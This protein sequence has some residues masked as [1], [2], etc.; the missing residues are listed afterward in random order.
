MFHYYIGLDLGQ[1]KDY[2]ALS[3]LEEPLWIGNEIAW[4]SYGVFW[5]PEVEVGGW[6]LPSELAPLYAARAL[7]VNWTY[8]RPAQ[9]P[10]Y[11]R[12]L[13]RFELGTKYDAI[14]ARVIRL[15][16]SEPIRKRLK[17]TRC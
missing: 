6:V 1:S 10:L 3:L 8:G 14:I 17:H 11:L 9:P 13:E 4:D 16:K 5:N 15:L 12:H 2:T 7:S